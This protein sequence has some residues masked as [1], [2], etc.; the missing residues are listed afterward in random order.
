MA[1]HFDS[2]AM[3]VPDQRYRQL[4]MGRFL[5]RA[6]LL[7][8]Q[9][10]SGCGSKKGN[11]VNIKPAVYM[12][13]SFDP[14]PSDHWPFDRRTPWAPL[15]VLLRKSGGN[16]CFTFVGELQTGEVQ[17]WASFFSWY[18]LPGFWFKGIPKGSTPILLGVFGLC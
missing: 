3:I 9:V 13:V 2:A 17:K 8:F 18:Q 14:Y 7:V 12:L 16:M 15:G 10:A 5:L 11:P 6:H 1:N 4:C